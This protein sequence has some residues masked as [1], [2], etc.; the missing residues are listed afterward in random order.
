M[1]GNEMFVPTHAGSMTR[2]TELLAV[3]GVM[4]QYPCLLDCGAPRLSDKPQLCGA[5]ITKYGDNARRTL[6]VVYDPFHLILNEARFATPIE[7]RRE[8]MVRFIR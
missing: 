7:S 5:D 8:M 1:H 6:F 4:I 2:P 3:P